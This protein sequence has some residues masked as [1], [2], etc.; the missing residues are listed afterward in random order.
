MWACAA[1]AVVIA[2]AW[3]ASGWCG[4]LIYW[5]DSSGDGVVSIGEGR[6]SCA[7]F[8]IRMM[9]DT[10]AHFDS[11]SQGAWR[12]W[13]ESRSANTLG[14]KYWLVIVPLWPAFL[15]TAAGAAGLWRLDRWAAA[16]NKGRCPSCGYDL[17]GLASGAACPEC[18]AAAVR[19]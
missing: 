18:G 4:G 8:S 5:R 9:Q 19:G 12:W 7:R 6:V 11:R 13:F 2:L 14:V 1:L 15:I 10:G 17:R 16:A 3:V